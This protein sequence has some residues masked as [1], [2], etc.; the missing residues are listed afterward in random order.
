MT[1]P[2]YPES[3]APASGTCFAVGTDAVAT[4]NGGTTW[5]KQSASGQAVSCPSN[6]N[7]FAVSSNNSILATINGGA[8]WSAQ[9]LPLPAI[10]DAISCPSTS[11]CFAAGSVMLATTNGG[12]TWTQQPFP[13]S[14]VLGISCASTK[15]CVAV[16]G[17]G[18]IFRTI[19][20]L[21]WTQEP[22]L[23]SASLRAV[24]CPT[25]SDCIIVGDSGL[26]FASTDGGAT[27]AGQGAF[28][29]SNFSS[30][31]CVAPGLIGGPVCEAGTFLG[32]LYS[33]SGTWTKETQVE[34]AGP[35]GVELHRV[36]RHCRK[37]SVHCSR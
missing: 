14:T 19:D 15:T 31:S 10:L 13:G 12:T 16:G 4:T 29:G 11:D 26:I 32:E 30:V 1:R 27:W 28:A 25:T 33:G 2:T 17:G 5:S 36:C 22:K 23:T 37:F 34:P 7:C 24:S 21:H 6:S 3:A 9:K 35:L 20:G 8:T 18:A